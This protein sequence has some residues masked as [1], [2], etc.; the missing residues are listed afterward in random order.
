M[1][2][3]ILVCGCGQCFFVFVIVTGIEFVVVAGVA[4]ADVVSVT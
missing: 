3:I 2:G 1:C 4:S